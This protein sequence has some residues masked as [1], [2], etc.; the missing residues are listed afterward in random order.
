M[1]GIDGWLK[2]ASHYVVGEYI[3]YLACRLHRIVIFETTLSVQFHHNET[4][5]YSLLDSKIP[6]AGQVI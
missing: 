6:E 1:G 5:S 4:W 2:E 3:R